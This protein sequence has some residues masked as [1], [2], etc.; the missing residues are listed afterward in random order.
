MA[1]VAG[2]VKKWQGQIVRTEGV[3]DDRSRV[4][5]AVVELKD[6]YG[7]NSLTDAEPLVFGRFVKAQ[8][9]GRFAADIAI[10]PRHV[11]TRDD[12]ILIVKDNKVEIRELN[13]VRMDEGNVYVSE[14]LSVGEQY[15]TSVIPNP[16]NG[17]TVRTPADI[18]ESQ[19]K[20]EQKEPVDAI[21]QTQT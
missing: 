14:G 2:K 7:L 6:P 17:M 5:Y 19:S 12:Q 4:T 8:V 21:A 10:V 20:P 15:V 1:V 13:I 3:V 11:L 16:M 9:K 18:E